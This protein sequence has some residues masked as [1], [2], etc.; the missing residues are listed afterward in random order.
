MR[1]WCPRRKACGGMRPGGPVQVAIEIEPADGTI[2]GRF[3]VAGVAG[4][5]FFGWLEL[6]DLL[7]RAS[8]AHNQDSS[9]GERGEEP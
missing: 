3:A 6:L 1:S 7:G 4:E 8:D 9:P 5:Q 2:R